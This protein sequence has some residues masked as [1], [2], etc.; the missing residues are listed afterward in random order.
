MRNS[1]VTIVKAKTAGSKPKT[2]SVKTIIGD[3]GEKTRVYSVSNNSPNL[4]D[5]LLYA[6]QKGVDKAREEN[7]RFFGNRAGG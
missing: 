4:Q 5:D 1:E 7:L 3:D 2:V 6:F